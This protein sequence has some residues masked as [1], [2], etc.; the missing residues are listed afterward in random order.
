MKKYT[1]DNGDI[2]DTAKNDNIVSYPE[3]SRHI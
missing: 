3:K 1:G 2:G